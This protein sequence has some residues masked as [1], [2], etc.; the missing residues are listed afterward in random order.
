VR[1]ADDG[2]GLPQDVRA[3]LFRAQSDASGH[4]LGLSIARELAERNGGVLDLVET[5]RGTTFVLEL[6]ALATLP[7][8]DTG[9]M[10][11]LGRRAS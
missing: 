4:G 3:R 1:I 2:P 9:A 7:T 6:S 11:S 8:E 10:R 5:A